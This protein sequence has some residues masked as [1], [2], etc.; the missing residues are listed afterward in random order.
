MGGNKEELKGEEV[1]K[2][3]RREVSGVDFFV[4]IFFNGGR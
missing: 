1:M 3:V 2:G 4:K